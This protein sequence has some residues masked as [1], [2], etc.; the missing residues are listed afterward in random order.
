MLVST[1]FAVIDAKNVISTYRLFLE[2]TQDAVTKQFQTLAE[3]SVCTYPAINPADILAHKMVI[4]PATVEQ[5]FYSIVS[6]MF[7]RMELAN[8]ESRAL[9]ATRNALLPKL[10]SGEIDVRKVEVA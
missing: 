5:E 10:M 4:P 3:Q 2:L 7:E 8:Q 9:A 1:G 6:P